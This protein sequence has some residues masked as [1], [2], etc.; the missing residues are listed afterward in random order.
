MVIGAPRV[1]HGEVGGKS[2]REYR[3]YRRTVR[4][5]S[6]D[7]YEREV[8]D[9]VQHAGDRDEHQRRRRV[10]ESAENCSE[11]VVCEHRRQSRDVDEDV[12]A[13]RLERLFRRAEQPYYRVDEQQ[14]PD[15]DDDAHDGE[16]RQHR[17]D[18]LAYLAG[19]SSAEKAPYHNSAAKRK[20]DNDAVD[21]KDEL[22]SDRDGREA[23]RVRELSDDYHIRRAVERLK[24]VRRHIWDCETRQQQRNITLRQ[25]LS[26]CR[27]DAGEKFL[28]ISHKTLPHESFLVFQSLQKII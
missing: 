19:L 24:Q 6:E 7:A 27:E 26:A 3:S 25:R 18:S 28:K 4:A 2:L 11:R 23:R 20:A 5:H 15:C 12:A 13:R 1:N 14:Q 9:D 22:A 10:A 16:E 8:A 17:A 21:H